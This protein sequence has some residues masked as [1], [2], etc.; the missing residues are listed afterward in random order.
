MASPIS[1]TPSLITP[2]VPS[3]TAQSSDN[4]ALTTVAMSI[5]SDGEAAVM[6]LKNDRSTTPAL[7]DSFSRPA[8]PFHRQASFSPELGQMDQEILNILDLVTLDVDF[9]INWGL[10][11][12]SKDIKN[13]IDKLKEKFDNE[14]IKLLIS[15][16]DTNERI[17]FDKILL[18]IFEIKK[19]SSQTVFINTE[20]Q[21]Q[22][23]EE[24]IPFITKYFARTYSIRIVQNITKSKAPLSESAIFSLSP[25]CF[26]IPSLQ[27]Y[28]ELLKPVAKRL[29][30]SSTPKPAFLSIPA[31]TLSYNSIPEFRPIS[32]K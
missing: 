17:V 4:G 31:A 12:Y 14:T 11:Y 3:N 27:H 20:A 21:S 10:Q 7:L 13:M 26:G 1:Q 23:F 6:K 5:I 16:L 19:F 18:K 32:K 9:S 28:H 29:A 2:P 24:I 15:Q 8:R 30:H 22:G 25:M